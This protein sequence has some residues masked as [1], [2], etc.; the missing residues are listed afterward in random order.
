MNSKGDGLMETET[1]YSEKIKQLRSLYKDI[2]DTRFKIS[3]ELIKTAYN[4]WLSL[5]G[6]ETC[7]GTGTRVV[8]DTMDIMDGSCAEYGPCDNKECSE[9]TRERSGVNI[10]YKGK[11][12][13][14]SINRRIIED[15]I[16]E[17][18][19]MFHPILHDLSNKI[20]M[21][22]VQHR[23]FKKGDKVIVKSGRKVPVGTV[24]KIF[25]IKATSYGLNVGFKDDNENTYWNYGH[26]LDVVLPK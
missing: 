11:Y 13:Y 3:N 1:T 23:E 25:Y 9:Q 5:G 6:C 21:L 12:F 2:D 16:F 15:M 22:E 26:N 14:N 20:H 18:T 10:T 4:E 8:W 7:Q 17:K 19:K 24:G